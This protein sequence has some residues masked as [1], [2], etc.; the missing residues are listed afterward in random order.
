MGYYGGGFYP[1]GYPGGGGMGIRP[2]FAEPGLTVFPDGPVTIT[3]T[4]WIEDQPG[5][6]LQVRDYNNQPLANQTNMV[7]ITRKPGTNQV[8]TYDFFS[9]TAKKLDGKSNGLA[10]VEEYW[11]K[12]KG[13][14]VLC[15]SNSDVH[16]KTSSKNCDTI[17]P[18]FCKE[19][20]R[21][22]GDMEGSFGVTAAQCV[23]AEKDIA[24]SLNAD[25]KNLDLDN[26]KKDF[27]DFEKNAAK[28]NFK[29]APDTTVDMV[30]N[31]S[32]DKPSHM[33]D[34]QDF[35][36]L[37]TECRVNPDV[38]ILKGYTVQPMGGMFYP[39]MVPGQGYTR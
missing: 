13:Y 18:A 15:N 34:M 11:N 39:G 19:L 32:G 23:K 27:A 12:D 5:K 33:K 17:T 22:S 3:S 35:D 36:R 29:N 28:E 21:M 8:L 31:N 26:I 7:S 4:Q 38:Q 6:F 10:V 37:L 2:L 30:K 9:D 14:Y 1:F 24:K 25:N 20:Q 16:A